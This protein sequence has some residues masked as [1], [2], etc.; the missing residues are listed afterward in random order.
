MSNHKSLVVEKGQD[1]LRLDLWLTQKLGVMSRSQIQRLIQG[2]FV[3]VDSRR[4]K[5]HHKTKI[6]EQ[7]ELVIPPPQPAKIKA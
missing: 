1:G 4:I 5:E 7:V 6:G 2:G 3:R